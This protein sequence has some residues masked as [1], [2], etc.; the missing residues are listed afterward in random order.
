LRLG[1][2]LDTASAIRYPRDNV[3]EC[4][5]EDLVAPDLKSQAAAE[6]QV[7]KSRVLLGGTDATIIVYGALAESVITAAELLAEDNI[8]VQ[9]IDARFCKPI[10]GDMLTRVL[11]PGH[12]V[13]TV[14]DHSLQNGFGTAVLEY[15][16]NH[17]LPTAH[18]SRLGMPDR[19][20]SHATRKEQLT[21]IGLDPK[22]IAASVRDAIH[23]AAGARVAEPASVE[24]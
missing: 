19:L 17:T 13:L 11:E 8:S 15:A 4:N 6:W 2:S 21:E 5:F 14:E 12:P 1:L 3:P 22:G 10:D 16:V 20:I 7:G 18:L 24:A 23:S 9:V